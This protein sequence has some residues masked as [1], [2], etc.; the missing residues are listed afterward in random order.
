MYQLSLTL[1]FS[2]LAPKDDLLSVE[3]VLK[4]TILSMVWQ[5]L[6]TTAPSTGLPLVV[7]AL[8]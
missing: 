7:P 5:V 2:L 1:S 8:G 3:G 6:N 4:Q